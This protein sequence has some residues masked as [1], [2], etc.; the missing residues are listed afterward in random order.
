VWLGGEGAGEVE[1]WNGAHIISG[2]CTVN[3]ITLVMLKLVARSLNG[4]LVLVEVEEFVY[5]VL[6]NLVKQV[7]KLYS[8]EY[9]N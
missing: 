2:E 9:V 7:C 5:E 4:P 6:E 8:N 3:G 1:V